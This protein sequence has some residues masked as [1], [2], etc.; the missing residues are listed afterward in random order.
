MESR[1]NVSQLLQACNKVATSNNYK[2]PAN[3]VKLSTL[4]AEAMEAF[5]ED[6]VFG[7]TM[8]VIIDDSMNDEA[9]LGRD[10]DDYSVTVK[11]T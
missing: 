2:G 4:H 11:L 1:K 5:T 3:F 10:D 7:G 9:L 8:K 6:G